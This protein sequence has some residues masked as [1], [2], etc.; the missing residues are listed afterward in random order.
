VNDTQILTLVLTL[1][2]I[3]GASWIN[4][5]RLANLNPGI[6]E[7]RDI[8]HADMKAMRADLNERFTRLEALVER[9]QETLMHMLAGTR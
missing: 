5:R 4:N 9:N 2:A 1:L 8:L 3:F 6:E 7:M